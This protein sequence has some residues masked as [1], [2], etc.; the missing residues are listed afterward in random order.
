MHDLV[1]RSA[2]C[3]PVEMH[4]AHACFA[5]ICG[6]TEE[7]LRLLA[8]ALD[9]RQATQAWAARHPDLE[10]LH[11]EPRFWLLVGRERQA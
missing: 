1:A 11:G 10:G 5:A 2:A 3:S 7:A 4:C 8:I 6:E 9:R